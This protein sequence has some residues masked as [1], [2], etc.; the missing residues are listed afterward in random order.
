MSATDLNDIRVAVHLRP[1]DL[2]AALRRDVLR[3]LSVAAPDKELSPKWL[4]DERGCELFDQITRLPEYYPTRRERSI[5]HACAA[6]VAAV[7]QADTLVELGSG[8]SDKT[9]LLLDA[10][11]AAG[12]LRRFAPFD[13]AEPTL[14]AAAVRI[15][16][17]YPGIEIDAVVG[18]F[19]THLAHLP[20][21]GSRL[22]AFLGGTIG[23]LDPPARAKLL[24]ELADAM[25]PGDSFLLGTDL[26]KDRARLVAAYDD[27]AGV[28]AAFNRNVLT[29]I[30]RELGATFEPTRFDHVARFDE[31]HQWIE[32]GLRSQIAQV[33]PVADLGIEIGFVAGEEIRTE[34]SAKFAP[35]QVR[36]ELE[37]AGLDPVGWW[38]DPAGDFAVSLA[39][40]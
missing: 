14:R 7:T 36:D 19:E 29:V 27:D 3:G 5:L 13:V 1:H 25:V 30:N 38:T 11:A 22:V 24:A 34:I 20:T 23:N 32:M 28:T 15:V 31:D 10:L 17:E 9:R 2:A 39:V 40:R 16:G 35:A 26:V 12:T 21:G 33:V 4:Y 8:T 6:E 37:T 18:D